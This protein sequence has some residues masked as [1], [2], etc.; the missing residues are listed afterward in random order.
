MK[1]F[2]NSYIGVQTRESVIKYQFNGGCDKHCLADIDTLLHADSSTSRLTPRV[3]NMALLKC[4][5]CNN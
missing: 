3:C 5:I 2:I 1:N 4:Y